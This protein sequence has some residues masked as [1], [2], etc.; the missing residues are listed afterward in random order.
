MCLGAKK[1]P[2]W[3]LNSYTAKTYRRLERKEN[4]NNSTKERN[5]PV[6]RSLN[7][8][9]EVPRLISAAGPQILSSTS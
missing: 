7:A 9:A 2:N 8:H 3:K 6:V 1:V 5:S 4:N